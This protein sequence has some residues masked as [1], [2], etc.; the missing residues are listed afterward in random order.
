MGLIRDLFYK[1]AKYIDDLPTIDS[2]QAEIEHLLEKLDESYRDADYHR[3]QSENTQRQI[4]KL[5]Q[6]N[7]VKQMKAAEK[8]SSEFCKTCKYKKGHSHVKKGNNNHYIDLASS[9]RRQRNTI[10]TSVEFD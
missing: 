10:D 5:N 8:L 9:P 3:R 2:K 6:V 1:F 7:E 4:V